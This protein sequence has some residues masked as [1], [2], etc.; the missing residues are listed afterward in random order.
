VSKIGEIYRV[1]TL[2]PKRYFQLVASDMSQLNSD[3]IAVFAYSGALPE[4]PTTDDLEH[5]LK[6]GVDFFTHTTVS[7]GPMQHLWS[8]IG[9]ADPV[10]YKKALFKD[11]DYGDD[12][13][14]IEP[15]EADHYHRW[16][17]WK[18]GKNWKQIGSKIEKYPEAELG[19]VY[20]PSDIVYRIEHG[21]YPGVSY[22]GQVR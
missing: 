15:Y 19:M 12:L 21:E 8:R 1:D 16:V 6:S 2:N 7:A 20:P 9:K 3:V 4:K 10:N 22:Y 5:V 17:I 11:V 14:D 18:V 13:P